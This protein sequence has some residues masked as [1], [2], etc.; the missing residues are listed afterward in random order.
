MIKIAP[1]AK[2]QSQTKWNEHLNDFEKLMLI[3]CLKEEKL[4]F[5]ITE[6][7]KTKLGK[8]FCESPQVSL[9]LLWVLKKSK[10]I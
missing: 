8:A 3:K 5:F 1:T 2:K 10:E 9:H 4:V 7:V 6:F